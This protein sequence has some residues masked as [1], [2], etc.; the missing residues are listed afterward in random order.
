M[1]VIFVLTTAF[2]VS[3][4]SLLRGDDWYSNSVVPI[5]T[6]V[7]SRWE[8][9]G[10]S[11]NGNCADSAWDGDRNLYLNATASVKGCSVMVK[12]SPTQGEE[13]GPA[14]SNVR[15]GDGLTDSPSVLVT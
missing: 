4:E 8:V 13:K 7:Q 6:L 1:V 11:T 3:D 15:T 2:F 9:N 5:R 14:P 10:T 12:S